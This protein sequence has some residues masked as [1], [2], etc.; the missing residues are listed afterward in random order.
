MCNKIAKKQHGEKSDV[1]VLIAS[2]TLVGIVKL[3]KF[4]AAQR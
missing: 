3:A 4:I 2:S 1:I